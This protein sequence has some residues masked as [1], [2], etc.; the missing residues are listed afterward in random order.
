VERF[1]MMSA[2]ILIIYFSFGLVLITNTIMRILKYATPNLFK[3]ASY[4]Y[5]FTL[6]FLIIPIYLFTYNFPKT[7]LH[8][9]FIGDQMA[10]DL[11][12][13]LPKNSVLFVSGDTTLFNSLYLQ[14]ARG[15]RKDIAIIN[16]GRLDYDEVFKKEK[17]EIQRKNPKML[18]DVLNV[19]VVT[20]LARKR[21]VFSMFSI[22]HKDKKNGEIAWMPYGLV[23]KLSDNNDRQTTEAVFL[24]NQEK[25]WKQFH[26]PD[27]KTDKK[28]SA[29]GLSL[30]SIP[31]LYSTASVNI[32]NY[33]ISRYN[34]IER[35]KEYYTRAIEFAPNETGGYRGLGYYYLNR[36][37][38][39]KAE[40]TLS[41]VIY[42]EP[43]NKKAY[44]LLYIT[45]RSC[46]RDGKKTKLLEEN[47][48]KIFNYSLKDNLLMEI[49]D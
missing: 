24:A 34:D 39:K 13:P 23:L 18:E 48:Y 49:K 37:D 30:A 12:S 6:V 5:F 16:M 36:R 38:C 43:M 29:H 2:M 31:A 14:Y 17:K 47:F 26:F 9:L 19:I 35:A 41:K 33:L 46:L 40:D 7:D 15:I 8:D 44:P 25:L 1:Y 4:K 22:Q 28:L 11:L 3:S 21:P 32:G 45:Y 10:E 27:K 42:L 20:S